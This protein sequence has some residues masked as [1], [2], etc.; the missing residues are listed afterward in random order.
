MAESL[1]TA[2][3]TVSSSKRSRI[4]AVAGAVL[5]LL[6]GGAVPPLVLALAFPI[7][8]ERTASSLGVTMLISLPFSLLASFLLGGPAFLVL[9]R[10][11]FANLPTALASGLVIGAGVFYGLARTVAPGMA[12]YGAAGA[13]AGAAC[14]STW[15]LV[16]REP[17][18][19]SFGH[20]S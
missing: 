19:E 1:A 6:V 17:L 14:L 12:V 20:R 11:G 2:L 9:Y 15:K 13:L 5:G 3:L 4:R 16:A 18:S 10:V 7:G 8:G